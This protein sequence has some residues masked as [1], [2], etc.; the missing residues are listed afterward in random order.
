MQFVCIFTYLLNI[1]RKF[2]FL[3]SQGNV[4]T[5]LRWGGY[6]CVVFVANFTSFPAVQKFW[7]SVKIWQSYTEFKDG[8]FFWDTVYNDS[9]HWQIVNLTCR[10][11]MNSDKDSDALW[12]RRCHRERRTNE[13]CCS[14][15]SET[16]QVTHHRWQTAVCHSSKPVWFS[17]TKTKTTMAKN[18]KITKS[19][20]KTKTKTKKCWKLKQN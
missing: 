20:T 11:T 1:C 15:A 2:E 9:V 4:A 3:I 6:C 17:L 13:W 14:Y 18:E 19:L 8:N 16:G 7:K 12:N 10:V 5:R